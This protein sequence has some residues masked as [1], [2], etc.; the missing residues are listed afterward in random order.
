MKS[1]MEYS[2]GTVARLVVCMTAQRAIVRL[3][4]KTGTFPHGTF[5]LE[6]TYTYTLQQVQ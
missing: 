1:M 3:N 5:R 4:I 2:S 6:I